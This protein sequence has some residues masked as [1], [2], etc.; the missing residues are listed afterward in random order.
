MSKHDL[1]S[2]P[3]RDGHALKA[4]CQHNPACTAVRES[5]DH[6]NSETALLPLVSFVASPPAAGM[7]QI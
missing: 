4:Y 5:G 1:A 7:I 6:L 2:V 3:A